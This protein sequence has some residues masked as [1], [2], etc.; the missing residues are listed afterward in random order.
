MTKQELAQFIDHTNLKPESTSSEIE[1][2]CAEAK[3]FGFAS[4]CVNPL[5]VQL[6]SEKLKTSTV[7]VC[8]VV[9][10]P[11]GA[12]TTAMKVE[13]TR[14]AIKNGAEEI[15]MVIAVG[16]L[17]EN[18]ERYVENDIRQVVEAVGDSAIVKVIIE[19]CLLTKEEKNRACQLAQ[20]AG[21][22]FVKTSTGFNKAGATIE[23]VALMRSV[24]GKEMGVKAAGGIRDFETAMQM[25]E[26]GATRIGASASV[27]IINGL[28]K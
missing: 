27:Q 21:A 6:C 8:T 9:G 28:E 7:K 4:V 26:A 19:T 5:F 20:K 10:F 17:K 23:D 1:K 2:L 15:D 22:H 13:E 11:L 14:E 24:V 25:I 3:E 12:T 16:K 18:D